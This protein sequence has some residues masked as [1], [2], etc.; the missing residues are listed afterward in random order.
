MKP[1]LLLSFAALFTATSI[2]S[3]QVPVVEPDYNTM[4]LISPAY[5]GPFAFPVPDTPAGEINDKLQ[6]ELGANYAIGTIGGKSSKDY[7]FAPT[8]KISLPLWTDRASLSVYGEF[9]EFYNDSPATRKARNVSSEFPY[10]GNDAGSI[11]VSTN[12]LVLREGKFHPS[13]AVRATLL[14]ATGD[15]YE[16]ARHYDAPGYFF[17][18]SIGKTFDFSNA[19]T[20]RIGGGIGFVCWQVDRGRQ[21]D[22]LMVNAKLSYNI[23]FASLSAEYGQYSG[24]ERTS[25]FTGAERIT[26]IGTPISGD[27]PKVIKGR[28]DLC[29]GRFAPYVSAE[30]GLNN[31]PFTLVKAG[32][33]VNFGI[34]KKQ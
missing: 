32:L 14:S 1:L 25:K 12:I 15:E 13:V 3:A 16:K 20:L 29:F 30:Y 34:L 18:A 6:I 28:L 9:H 4:T 10:K 8:F 24:Y 22:A 7:T 33:A 17:D 5:F 27:C 19:G 31:Y 21:N 26:T 11:Y 2:C 23:R